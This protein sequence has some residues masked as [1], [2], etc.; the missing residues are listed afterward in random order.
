M[1]ARPRIIGTNVRSW[2]TSLSAAPSGTGNQMRIRSAD[3][4]QN[5]VSL[6]LDDKRALGAPGARAGA[7]G[8]LRGGDASGWRA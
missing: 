7:R 2:S 5:S 1:S 3:R 8:F 4:E 6:R